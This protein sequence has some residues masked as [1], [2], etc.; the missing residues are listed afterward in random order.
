[1]GYLQAI[2]NTY[3]DM[4]EAVKKSRI[5]MLDVKELPAIVHTLPPM[6]FFGSFIVLRV[7]K[8]QPIGNAVHP[9]VKKRRFIL[10][11]CKGARD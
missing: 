1:M 11:I 6:A 2:K 10:D 7:E 9:R 8:R 4:Q 5:F 3:H